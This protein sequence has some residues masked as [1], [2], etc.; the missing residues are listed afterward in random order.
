MYQQTELMFQEAQ[1]KYIQQNLEQLGQY[2]GPTGINLQKLSQ[3]LSNVEVAHK[4]AKIKLET[5][6]AMCSYL[7]M[8]PGPIATINT[9][10]GIPHASNAVARMNVWNALTLHLNTLAVEIRRSRIMSELEN[11]WT[12]DKLV[13][14][15]KQI[16]VCLC[17]FRQFIEET[18]LVP[19][20]ENAQYKHYQD[21]LTALTDHVKKMIFLPGQILTLG[22]LIAHGRNCSKYE[23]VQ[24]L[25]TMLHL[26]LNIKVRNATSSESKA[27]AIVQYMQI[28]EDKDRETLYTE[29]LQIIG[30]HYGFACQC[31]FHYDLN[32]PPNWLEFETEC[33]TWEDVEQLLKDERGTKNIEV[34]YIPDQD[35]RE[36]LHYRIYSGMARQLT[37]TSMLAQPCAKQDQELYCRAFHLTY[38]REHILTL[39]LKLMD[40]FPNAGMSFLNKRLHRLEVM[41]MLLCQCSHHTK[42]RELTQYK[43]S[44]VQS[45]AQSLKGH[46][47]DEDTPERTKLG[48]LQRQFVI[49]QIWDCEKAGDQIPKFIPDRFKAAVEGSLVIGMLNHM[50]P[51]QATLAKLMW[52]INEYTE[53]LTRQNGNHRL[54]GWCTLLGAT[55]VVLDSTVSKLTL[56][57]YTA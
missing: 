11:T 39:L 55:H 49:P 44:C 28:G 26:A 46:Q 38:S 19:I 17:T 5:A 33:P 45:W 20:P 29:T 53:S 27:E 42:F 24:R 4:S 57:V 9:L 41:N 34:Q 18:N 15:G 13:R 51:D 2:S 35:V 8:L 23:M 7:A 14:F 50:A 36:E 52:C 54:G 30:Q 56:A 22:V 6:R 10:K 1:G 21:F 25:I 12:M 31:P 43:S 32:L 16:D 48:G 3:E 47:R 37:N 40:H